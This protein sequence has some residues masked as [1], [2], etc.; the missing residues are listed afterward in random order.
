MNSRSTKNALSRWLV[1][2]VL[3]VPLTP[4]LAQGVVLQHVR[5]IPADSA[6]WIIIDFGTRMNYLRHFPYTVGTV[7]QIQLRADQTAEFEPLSAA[8]GA[9][10]DTRR[11]ES[12]A[13]STRLDEPLAFVTYEGQVPGGPYLTV[14]F[15]WAVNFTVQEGSDGRSIEIRAERYRAQLPTQLYGTQKTSGDPQLDKWM[16]DAL[17]ALGANDNARAIVLLD[18][19][20]SLPPHSFSQQSKELMGIA[21]ERRG[22]L[23][24]ARIEYLE[25]L[26]LYPDSST[27]RRVNERL[28]DL[29]MRRNAPIQDQAPTT[30]APVVP[31]IATVPASGVPTVSGQWSQNY[32]F[33]QTDLADH[34]TI[35]STSLVSALNTTVRG[36]NDRF[37]Y[38]AFADAVHTHYTDSDARE[39]AS[40]NSLYLQIS[41]KNTAHNAILGRQYN[42]DSGLLGRFDGL[43]LDIKTNAGYRVTGT[44]AHPAEPLPDSTRAE[45]MGYGISWRSDSLFK[46]LQSTAYYGEQTI[47]GLRD[48]RAVGGSLR[49]SGEKFSTNAAVDYDLSFEGFNVLTLGAG[50]RLGNTDR[51]DLTYD[52]RVAPQWLLSSALQF[53][54][55]DR[56]SE[57]AAQVSPG[58]IHAKAEQMS[59]ETRRLTLSLVKLLFEKTWLFADVY[60]ME[61]DARVAVNTLTSSATTSTIAALPKYGPEYFYSAQTITSD[62]W[63]PGNAQTFGVRG[64]V[65]ASRDTQALFARADAPI[66]ERWRVGPRVQI[67]RIHAWS[68][69]SVTLKPSIGFKLEYRFGER[70]RFDADITYENATTEK[71]NPSGDY[72]RTALY[73]GYRVDY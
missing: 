26:R 45:R 68:D 72:T 63:I 62:F 46:T 28:S 18:K 57:L 5:V 56:F 2:V 37:T 49:Y 67:D 4:A 1:L 48:R 14:R 15:K 22:E 3:L 12:L 64:S 6:H 19:L 38:L 30:P 69:D 20:L 59:N 53:E 54:N 21:R 43:M 33:D 31:V 65:G 13:P 32:L 42:T 50:R 55:L 10:I 47:E 73:L 24:R 17:K 27:A 44:I 11:R 58:E 8:S 36:A 52:Q 7:V 35:L 71:M 51:I 70:V 40:V 60:A 66:A 61:S 41:H 9:R 39:R 23:E 34:T 16:S 29:E 25:F